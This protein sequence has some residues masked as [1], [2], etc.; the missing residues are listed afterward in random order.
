MRR[1][2]L[3][4]VCLVLAILLSG[5][6]APLALPSVVVAVPPE[7]TT[8]PATP[9]EITSATLNGT[10]DTLNTEDNVT[11]SFIWGYAAGDYTE[12]TANQTM[13]TTGVF[14]ADLTGLSAGTTY[15]YRAKAV[16][17]GTTLGN[18][19]SFTTSTT[20]PTVDTSAATNL[21]TTS[22]TLNGNLI[23]LGTA[24]SVTVSFE[25]GTSTS[26]GSETAAQSLTA[27]GAFS[28]NLTGLTANTTHHFRAKAV[29]HG[30]AVYGD[31]MTFPTEE[32][33]PP[34]QPIAVSPDAQEVSITPT[35]VSS[36]FSDDPGDFQVASEWQIRTVTGTGSSWNS[37]LFTSGTDN[38]NLTNIIV[39]ANILDYSTIYFWRVIHQDNY[40]EW[41]DPSAEK[42]FITSANQL[43]SQ[44]G[45]SLPVDGAIDQSLTPTL[46]CSAFS[47]P[48]AGDAHAASQWQIRTIL[49]DYTTGLVFDSGTDN[50]NLTSRL[51]P[52]GPL[53]Y[54][55]T[56]YWHVRHQDNYEAWSP[57]SAETSFIT[58]ANQ[59]PNAPINSL[60]AN[61]A[62]DIGLTPTLQSSAFNDPG[63]THAASQWQITTVAG[64]WDASLVFDNVTFAPNLTSTVVPSGPLSYYTTYYWRVRH[65]DSQEVWSAWSSPT[66]FTTRPPGTGADF[67]ANVTA[68][69][70]GQSVQFT[71]TSTGAI[72][73]WTWDFGDGT[74]PVTWSTRPSDGKVSHT[75][76]VAGTYTVA[77]TISDAA[78]EP[79]T[80]TKPDYINVFPLPA[81]D[82]SA[83]ATAIVPGEAVA[84]TN[85]SSGGIPPLTY[86]WDFDD[87]GV[88]DSTSPNPSHSYDATGL[89][90]ISLRVTDARGNSTTEKRAGY[91]SVSNAIAP[92]T[93][94]PEGGTIQ[95]ADG[96]IAVTFP[97]GAVTGEPTLNIDGLSPSAVAKAP[98]GYKLGGTCF[99]TKVVDAGGSTVGM[100]SRAV[101]V[102]VKYSDEDLAAAGG[103]PERLV[104]A[105]Y[106][107]ATGKW[108]ILDTTLSKEDRSLT[109]NTT[110]F[111]TW[112]V[113]AKK[114]SGGMA[115]WIWIVL[116]IAAG[117]AVAVV[118]G[119]V[120]AIERTSKV[121]QEP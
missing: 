21:A 36:E 89:Y 69:I 106:N 115:S 12:A 15:Y 78:V 99:A 98:G 114:P 47:D 80:E 91:I 43:P 65:Q 46:A 1:R 9:I 83:S 19:V 7:V 54:S 45:N 121:R 68:L 35:L 14:T 5:V 52:S 117:L 24:S 8:N 44:P 88:V 20:A 13:N 3:P 63:D 105:Q 86:A 48:D 92:H 39:P 62:P 50:V 60:P 84:F 76:A 41:S 40:L 11:V 38:V 57:W 96:R 55:T 118:V 103:N 26:Y 71:D 31:D 17:D 72:V 97:E 58:A 51:V 53:A 28:A 37:P 111:G 109:A 75:Y 102:T 116:G 59:P 30:S 81:A 25:W 4:Y 27:I 119:R 94:P 108:T 6:L 49:G 95:T 18:E 34:N 87:D 70:V 23:S 107:D 61:L 64:N 22:A 2:G 74:A 66:S 10:L 100:P 85:Q 32:N 73:S 33:Q 77:L 67:V 110:R 29:G 120:V 104:L 101:T 90:T 42:W 112:A 93:I 79:Y 16:G 113:M 82:F 56:Y